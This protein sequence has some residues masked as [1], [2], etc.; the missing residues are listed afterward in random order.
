MEE[1]EQTEDLIKVENV[2][3]SLSEEQVKAIEEEKISRQEAIEKEDQNRFNSDL[4]FFEKMQ[5]HNINKNDFDHLQIVLNAI[6]ND[7][8]NHSEEVTLSYELLKSKLPQN[9]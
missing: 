8:N 1:K 2:D 3:N 4:E 7:L 6:E 9:T 5:K